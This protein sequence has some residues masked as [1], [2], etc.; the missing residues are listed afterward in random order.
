MTDRS[1]IRRQIRSLEIQSDRVLDPSLQKFPGSLKKQYLDSF[2]AQQTPA[3]N[4]QIART[5]TT[6]NVDE[7]YLFSLFIG[8]IS[9][10]RQLYQ[11]GQDPESPGECPGAQRSGSAI[12]SRID[13]SPGS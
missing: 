4:A 13:G 1:D 2:R 8:D 9:H 12:F 11:G 7:I 6:F 3:F 10:L 5:L